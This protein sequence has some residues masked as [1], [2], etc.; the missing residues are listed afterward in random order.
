MKQLIYSST[1][2]M[3]KTIKILDD[4][5]YDY[6]IR[7]YNQDI[8]DISIYSLEDRQKIRDLLYQNGISLGTSIRKGQYKPSTK[9]LNHHRIGADVVKRIK[10]ATAN[11]SYDKPNGLTPTYKYE[12]N[13][14]SLIKLQYMFWDLGCNLPSEDE[15]DM[16]R[17]DDKLF[18]EMQS[19]FTKICNALKQEGLILEF[20]DAHYKGMSYVRGCWE[21]IALNDYVN[22]E[23]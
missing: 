5:D 7:G 14:R 12:M 18:A 2:V 13:N 23:R 20:S 9:P 4:N 3:D 10:Q 6:R 1:T 19:S 11:I 22:S 15:F 8:L 17:I 16:T 21:V